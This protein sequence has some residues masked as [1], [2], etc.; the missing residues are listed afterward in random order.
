MRHFHALMREPHAP[1]QP[2]SGG[3]AGIVHQFKRIPS[4]IHAPIFGHGLC[5]MIPD[6]V[7]T[8][9]LLEA[10]APSARLALPPFPRKQEATLFSNSL[11]NSGRN[12][13]RKE[14]KN[15]E[16]AN[17]D[18]LECVRSVVRPAK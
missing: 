7:K 16:T 1:C 14:S 17:L 10:H 6:N 2:A 5:L 13:C 15:H 8:K 9:T 11:L 4:I 12:K 18:R 3:Q